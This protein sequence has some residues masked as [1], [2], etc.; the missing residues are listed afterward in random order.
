MTPSVDKLIAIV[1]PDVSISEAVKR[2]ASEHVVF[3][4]LVAVL[5]ERQRVLGILNNGDI[6]RLLARGYDFSNPVS[7]VMIPDPIC[8]APQLS[9]DEI[10]ADVY[11]QVR[12][13]PR[14]ARENVA[15]VLVVDGNGK[16]EGVLDFSGM[17]ARH[18]RQGGKVA[19]YGL[20]FVGLT[21]AVALASRGYSVTGFDIDEKMIAALKSGTGHVHEPGLYDMLSACLER[22][23]IDFKLSGSKDRHGVAIIAVGTPVND[24]GQADLTALEAVT[25]S[26]GANLSSG[27]LVL[28]RSTVPV[29]TT[30]DFVSPLLE[31]LSGLV[32]GTDFHIAFAPERTVEGRAMRELQTLPQIVGGLTSRCAQKASTFFGT[33]ANAVVQVDGLE[34]AELVKLANNSFRDLSFAFSNSLALLSDRFNVDAFRLISS[35]NE[36]YPRNTIPLPSPGVGGYCLTKDPFLFAAVAPEMDHAVLARSGR[37]ANRLAAR[38]PVKAFKRWLDRQGKPMS[39]CRVLVIGLAFKGQ[40]ET[41]DLRGSAALDVAH[42]LKEAGVEVLGWDCVVSPEDIAAHG[43]RPV[44]PLEAVADVDGVFI[45]N[46][47]P[48]N[49]PAGLVAKMRQPAFLFDGWS[50]IDALQVE[51]HPGL[52]YATMG[53][54]TSES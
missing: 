19:V 3:F 15:Y 16:L 53:Y 49:V 45:L 47:H 38:Y 37:S 2:M 25:R 39:G 8:V 24:E 41:N 6:I 35:A 10:I 7:S 48:N 26:I 11:R 27:D 43:I 52:V 9:T 44:S 34:A 17:V 12:L 46:N 32:A 4:G 40:P 20:G 30:R 13:K 42:E 50:L 18:G 54:M 5:D 36:G 21:L 31:E 28:L 23:T 22:D 1:G 51:Q 29:G 14:L 33:L